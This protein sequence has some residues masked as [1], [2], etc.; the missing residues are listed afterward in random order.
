MLIKLWSSHL[1]TASIAFFG[2]SEE[3]N[4]DSSTY[5]AFFMSFAVMEDS[6]SVGVTSECYEITY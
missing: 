3:E 6:Q 2:S 4:L 5:G 1:R